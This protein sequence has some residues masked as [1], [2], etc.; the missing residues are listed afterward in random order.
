MSI[1]H[2]H[3]WFF[4]NSEQETAIQVSLALPKERFEM[5]QE[6]MGTV[7]YTTCQLSGSVAYDISN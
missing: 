5:L 3:T 2:L 1:N 7:K 4:Q 6:A